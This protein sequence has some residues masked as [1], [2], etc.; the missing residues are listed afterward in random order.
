M[1]ESYF[2]QSVSAHESALV[3]IAIDAVEPSLTG[4][5]P[6]LDVSTILEHWLALGVLGYHDFVAV[7]FAEQVVVVEVGSRVDEG[8][9]LVGF[10]HEMQELEE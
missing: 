9:L 7:Q 1:S 4:I 10:L 2:S 3:H 8:L 5:L 6:H